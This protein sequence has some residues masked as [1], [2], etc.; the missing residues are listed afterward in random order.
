MRHPEGFTRCHGVFLS[1]TVDLAPGKK[2][3][4]RVFAGGPGWYPE[5]DAG[6]EGGGGVEVCWDCGGVIC[7]VF[8]RGE[9]RQN[10]NIHFVC[11]S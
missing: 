11:G 3:M 2:E 9:S 6:F 10:D 8:Q 5:G 4:G 1:L 7:F